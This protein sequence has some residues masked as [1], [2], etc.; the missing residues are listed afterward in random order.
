[1]SDPEEEEF[2]YENDE[3]WYEDAMNALDSPAHNHSI[4]YA[5]ED[6]A[7]LSEIDKTI[8]RYRNGLL[9]NGFEFIDL[10]NGDYINDVIGRSGVI[11]SNLCN[12]VLAFKKENS[13]ITIFQLFSD[14]E[15]IVHPVQLAAMIYVNKHLGCYQL[16]E[17][18]HLEE[19]LEEDQ[20]VLNGININRELSYKE[21]PSFEFYKSDNLNLNKKYVERIE[22]LD[23]RVF[24]FLNEYIIIELP[25]EVVSEYLELI[26]EFEV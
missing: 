24:E 10:Q 20:K 11:H 23:P 3:S 14:D 6:M 22:P 1:M 19:E 2:D 15:Q 13:Y 9:E 25:K 16:V 8:I 21:K 5:E 18:F 17:F 4:I 12:F 7:E 26:K